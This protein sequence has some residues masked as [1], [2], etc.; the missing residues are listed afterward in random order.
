[1]ATDKKKDPALEAL[2]ANSK[3][4]SAVLELSNAKISA[5]TSH[6]G[7]KIAAKTVSNIIAGRHNPTVGKAAAIA[8]ALHVELWQL[9]IEH[10]PSEPTEQK[11]LA[12]M[13]QAFVRLS[14]DER[15]T[16]IENV[17]MLSIRAGIYDEIFEARR[18]HRQRGGDDE[19]KSR[20]TK[21]GS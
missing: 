4:L 20:R 17:K 1:M 16:L 3:A 12:Q 8:H 10:L 7:P 2:A 6:Y 18:P 5:L 19:D 13:V 14:D 11:R 21:T 9:F 15:T